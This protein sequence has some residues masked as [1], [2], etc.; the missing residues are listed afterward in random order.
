M[1]IKRIKISE[2]PLAGND[3]TGLY[4]IGV[5][6]AG[7]AQKSVRVSME[8]FGMW[9]AAKVSVTELDSLYSKDAVTGEKPSRYTVTCEAAGGTSYTVGVLDMFSDSMRHQ[10]TQVLTTHYA[11]NAEGVLDFTLH[12]D[13]RVS[14]FFRSYHIQGGTSGTP[15]GTWGQWRLLC[16]SDVY[17]YI[18][19]VAENSLKKSDKGAA[20]GVASLGEDGKVPQ[21]QLPDMPVITAAEIDEITGTDNS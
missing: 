1:A 15:V 4:T 6:E 21:E 20:G 14:V 8:G 9:Q 18:A 16:D 11:M 12:N 5:Q 17:S 19:R 2:L 3:L 10:L 7:G 13:N